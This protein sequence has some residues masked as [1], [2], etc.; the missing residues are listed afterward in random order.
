MQSEEGGRFYRE[1]NLNM[2]VEAPENFPVDVPENFC[3]MTLAQIYKFIQFNNYLN[4]QSRSL[5]S[6]ISF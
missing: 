4:I 6:V 1:Q 2:I 3:W 5:L